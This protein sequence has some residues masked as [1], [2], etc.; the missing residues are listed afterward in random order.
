MH[1]LK[2]PQSAW[3]PPPAHLNVHFAFS[4][5]TNLQPPP[6][7]SKVHDVFARHSIWHPAPV[8]EQ[9]CSHVPVPHV[10]TLLQGSVTVAPEL[11][12]TPLS[13]PLHAA[14]IATTTLITPSFFAVD[15][16]T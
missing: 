6:G 8:P 10:Q 15:P 14:V 13:P 16:A 5:Q 11:L 4:P 3:Q 1:V 12:P 2:R 9:V 7:Q